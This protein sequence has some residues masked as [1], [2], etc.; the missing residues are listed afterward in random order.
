MEPDIAYHFTAVRMSQK[1]GSEEQQNE[2]FGNEYY[3]R[4]ESVLHRLNAVVTSLKSADGKYFEPY[5]R[6]ELE[7]EFH[8][9]GPFNQYTKYPDE[10]MV[11]S[12]TINK[13]IIL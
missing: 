9:G 8:L 2:Y 7:K 4:F 1:Q 3:R 11:F 13:I 5:T 10:N 6:A 12:I